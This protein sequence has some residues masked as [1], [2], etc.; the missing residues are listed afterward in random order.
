MNI[1]YYSNVGNTERFVEEKLRPLLKRKPVILPEEQVEAI[2]R[3]PITTKIVAKSPH[4]SNF[5]VQMNHGMSVPGEATI[6]VFPVYA[7][8]DHETGK[9]TDT[10]PKPVKEAIAMLKADRFTGAVV[11]GN[12]TFGTKFCHINPE[13]FGSVPIPILGAVEMSGTEREAEAIREKLVKFANDPNR[14]Y[15]QY[16][17]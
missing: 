2:R 8:A 12:R 1:I 6:I 17:A 11:C 5:V 4:S 10:I 9:L 13:E 7:R 3:G 15:Y 16:S 14:E